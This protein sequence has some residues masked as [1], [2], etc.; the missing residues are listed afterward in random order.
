MI[1]IIIR[2]ISTANTATLTG[3]LLF[4]LKPDD[5]RAG[6]TVVKFVDSKTG[7]YCKVYRQTACGNDSSIMVK[8]VSHAR[9][10][11]RQACP[12]LRRRTQDDRL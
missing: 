6:A 4:S 5:T 8:A 10:T 2:T 1:L 7:H 9:T 3:F 11:L 12:E